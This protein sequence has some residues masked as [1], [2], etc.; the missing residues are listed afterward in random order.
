MSQALLSMMGAGSA[1][2]P[3]YVDDVFSAY[4]RTGTGADATVT[5]NIDMTQGYMLWSKGRSGAT[6]HAIYDSAR[7]VT[8]DLVSNST[9]AQTTQS[10]GLKAVSSTG[11][12]V[13][14]LAKMNTNAATYV[15]WV[16]RKAA[17][18]FDV[19][20]Y[21][22]NGATGR[23]IAHSL[24]VA[25][26]MII[27]KST[28]TT[29]YWGVYHRS[30]GSSG[31]YLNATNSAG[32]T[33]VATG[34]TSS[35]FEVSSGYG[36][37][38]AN[39]ETYV[40]YLFAHDTSADGI[41]QCGSFT[42][43]GSGNAT[44]NLGWEPQWVLMKRSSATGNWSILDVMR[45]ASRTKRFYLYAESSSSEQGGTEGYAVG[46]KADGFDVANQAA[47]STYIYAAIRRPNKPPAVGTQVYNAIART[48][49][50]AA[51]TVTGVGFAPDLSV[52]GGRPSGGYGIQWFDRL[53]GATKGFEGSYS[54]AAE[55][56]DANS[57]TAYGMDGFSLGTD[58]PNNLV[59]GNA[60]TYINWFFKRAPGVFDIVCYTGTGSATTVAHS[61][62]VAPELMIVKKRSAADAWYVY[63]GDATD[64]LVLNTTAATADLDT[65][66]NDTAPTASVFTVGTHD[67][68]NQNT[69][70]FVA[71]LFATKAGISKCGSYTGNG[72]SQ[73]IDC[74]FTT[75]ARFVLIK[76]SSTTGAWWVFDTVRGIVASTDFGLQLNSTAAETTSA[77]AVDPDT[78]GIV[79]NE[80][81]TCSINANGVSYLF[82]AFA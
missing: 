60:V 16:F 54:T 28:G 3:T 32:V 26:G 13:G 1:S 77:D 19:V 49:T 17:K 34:H 27:S 61:L 81:A 45:G 29:G 38:N 62:G 14:S 57:V 36:I 25:P 53:R 43:D 63:A 72:T 66:W 79:V 64:Y 2:A 7:G 51:A 52:I 15:D 47:S 8:Y 55:V 68:V 21:T 40:A 76:A 74:G 42:T 78:S 69:G 48:G 20:T 31:L 35:T 6:D 82:L 58:S 33:G 44:V 5:T 37:N 65:I 10:T 39:G 22:G 50:G 24:G 56:T 46:P 18:F 23:Q 4:T 9:A 71:Y 11:H 59:N 80:E 73:T 41:I 12:T 67:D 75:G 30:L 70:T